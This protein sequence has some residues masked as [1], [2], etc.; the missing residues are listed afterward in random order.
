MTE[1]P[2]MLLDKAKIKEN[3]EYF[4]KELS[5]VFPKNKVLY[6][7]KTNSLDGAVKSLSGKDGFEVASKKELKLVGKT[8]NEMI[9]FNG[10]GKTM[11][12]LML[13]VKGGA[14]IIVDNESELEKILSLKVKPKEIGLRLNIV[15]K[16]KFGL[17]TEQAIKALQKAMESKVKVSLIHA[18]L[19]TQKSLKEFEDYLKNV[20]E[21][22]GKL[23]KFNYGFKLVDLGGGFPGRIELKERNIKLSDYFNLMKK[24]LGQELNE[25]TIVLETGRFIVSD[26]M[27][28]LTKVVCLKE[29]NDKNYAVLDAGINYL[30]KI[31]LNQYKFKVVKER[32]GKKKVYRLAGPLLF[33]NDELSSIN[34]LLR[35]GDLIQVENCG[36]YCTEMF[37]NLSYGKIKVQ[38]KSF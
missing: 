3:Y 10:P 38:E 12:E 29:L 16:N 18:H 2:V 4:K 11:E 6:S 5:K 26:A 9:V 23:K 17:S 28:L 33:G 31:T 14:I 32:I 21:K 7:V 1:T 22:L 36:A 13:G 34:A 35:E 25:K 15:E 37:W 30:P 19:G 20:K 27:Q 24:V 8:K